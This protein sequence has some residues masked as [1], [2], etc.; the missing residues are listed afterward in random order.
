ML[1]HAEAAQDE[2]K[3]LADEF[4]ALR[5]QTSV[6]T[7]VIDGLYAYFD[8]KTEP[9]PEGSARLPLDWRFLWAVA[10]VL[11]GVLVIGWLIVAILR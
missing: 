2:I 4:I 8:P 6:P 1:E 9:L 11:A 5:H 3:H 7:P 10:G